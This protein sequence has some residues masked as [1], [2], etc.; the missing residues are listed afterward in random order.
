MLDIIQ[1]DNLDLPDSPEQW[2]TQLA[3]PTAIEIT[4]QNPHSWRIA[5]VLVHGNEPSGFFAAHKF[6]KR[7]LQQDSE[8]TLTNLAIVVASVRAARHEPQFTH[9]HIPGE[10]D[11]NRRFGFHESHDNVTEL[12]KN[13]REYIV[14][15]QPQYVVDL[16]NTSGNGPA[17]AVS[18][19]DTPVARQLTS[20]FADDLV[21]TRLVVGSLMEQSLGCPIITIE[22]GGAQ[23]SEAH[24]IA[25]D[26]LS[27][28]AF[29]TSLEGTDASDIQVYHHP[30]RV[31]ALP[32]ISLD[33]KTTHDDDVDITLDKTI[34]RYNFG[35]TN[36]GDQLGWLNRNIRECLTAINDH[37]DE[38][39]DNFFKVENDKL[40]VRRKLRLFMATGRTDIALSDCLF[41]AVAL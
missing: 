38:M 16:H 5:S 18:V 1:A 28:F 40:I 12:A 33:H 41:Y 30:V 39:V 17:F 36:A 22:C 10:F 6:L 13:I 11:L 7:H 19:N 25:F 31:K 27:R 9:R 15:R 24:R 21:V 4:G 8:Q 2:L 3:H 34:E 14:A 35:V 32:G 23:M 29:T 37:G 26:G 20:L